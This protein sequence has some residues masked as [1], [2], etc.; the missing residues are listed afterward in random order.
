MKRDY[1]DKSLEISPGMGKCQGLPRLPTDPLY[2]PVPTN[3]IK[4]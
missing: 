1:T 2:P 3:P 4:Q